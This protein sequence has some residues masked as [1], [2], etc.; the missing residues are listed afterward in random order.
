MI[1]FFRLVI[2]IIL[3]EMN[4]SKEDFEKLKFCPFDLQNMP[5]NYNN[6]RND[7]FLTQISFHK[8]FHN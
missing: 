3:F 7:K 6:D 5:L 1:L 4:T 8:L 2:F